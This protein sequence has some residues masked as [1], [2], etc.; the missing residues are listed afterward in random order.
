MANVNQD[1]LSIS[2]VEL[3]N[4]AQKMKNEIENMRNALQVASTEME[5]T[6]DSLQGVAGDTIRNKYAALEQKFN[7]FY[8]AMTN[9]ATFLEKTATEYEQQEQIISK[10][11]ED[12]LISDYNE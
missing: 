8:Q 10:A 7:D 1:N 2:G 11:A 3:K 12:V 5:R 4:N 9:Y 6:R